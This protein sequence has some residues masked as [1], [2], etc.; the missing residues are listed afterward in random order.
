MKC[1]VLLVSVLSLVGFP[2]IAA[3]QTGPGTATTKPAVLV[4]L[5]T[6]EGCSSCPPAD[7]LLAA[8]DQDKNYHGIPVV[9]LSEHVDYWDH[10]GWR[11]PFSSPDWTQ[12]QND[13][14]ERF[15]LGSVYTPQ[16]VIDGTQQVNGSDGPK[17]ARALETAA[18][19]EQRVS[20]EIKDAV[21][22]GDTLQAVVNIPEASAK[23][24]N[25]YAV[26][27]D[28]KDTS[29][30]KR[31]ENAGHTLT[32]V[33]VARVLHKVGKLPGPYTGQVRISLPRGVPRGK[34][35]LI[36]FAQRGEN[37]EVL[38]AAERDV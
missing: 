21:W 23:G 16:M 32:N 1:F 14:N 6:S 38:G 20:I 37:G 4:E 22:S 36:I 18:A 31:G 11:D 27:A 19:Q 12:R 9:V 30:V 26:L 24:A 28:D 17:I 33:A 2:L 25:L 13:Y 7:N 15:H 8:L 10:E 5:F 29:D 3:S 34:M 35:R